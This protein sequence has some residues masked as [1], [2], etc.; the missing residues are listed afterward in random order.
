MEKEQKKK[1]KKNENVDSW[2][3]EM[4]RLVDEVQQ[5]CTCPGNSAQMSVKYWTKLRSGHD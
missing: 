3:L 2:N 1:K 5:Q 4:D